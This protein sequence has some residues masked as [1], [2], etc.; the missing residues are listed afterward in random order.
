MNEED[1]QI[2]MKWKRSNNK[3][4]WLQ[5]IIFLEILNGVSLN[6]I[7]KKISKSRRQIR[8]WLHSYESLGIKGL[9]RQP[10]KVNETIINNKE[11]KKANLIK[12]IHETPKLHGINRTSWSLKCLT[13][14][15][16]RNY[17][18]H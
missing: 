14:T 7:S 16:F 4:K 9:E 18:T 11:I 8:K 1:R 3:R 5:G 17:G 12:L 10:R 6:Q 15:Y 13:D 2:F